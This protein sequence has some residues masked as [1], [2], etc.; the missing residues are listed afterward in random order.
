MQETD[1]NRGVLIPYILIFLAMC[2]VWFSEWSP[3]RPLRSGVAWP[4]WLLHLSPEAW[5]LGIFIYFFGILW[6]L[7]LLFALKK[8]GDLIWARLSLRITFRYGEVIF[9]ILLLAIL[10]GVNFG[11][12]MRPAFM[13]EIQ[14]GLSQRDCY[15][16]L[17]QE[18]GDPKYCEPLP[19]DGYCRIVLAIAQKNILLCD[20]LKVVAEKNSCVKD[21]A[22]V[23][24]DPA[25]CERSTIESRDYCLD[26]LAQKLNNR[27]ICK[28]IT[29]D[30]LRNS[31]LGRN[32]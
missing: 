17:V 30:V 25:L 14:K 4:W 2:L 24:R 15:I 11:Y 1:K 13:C 18:T 27:N 8:V 7:I 12:T 6:V 31:C 10:L 28:E 16:G 29:Y 22:F 20:G 21:V 5:G 26:Y 23:M 9:H 19:G 32:E 3:L